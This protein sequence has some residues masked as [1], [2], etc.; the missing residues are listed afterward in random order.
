VVFEGPD[1]NWA[2]LSTAAYTA[3]TS[4]DN[5]INPRGL[6]CGLSRA[7]V[8]SVGYAADCLGAGVPVARLARNPA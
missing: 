7:T 8:R 3:D 5:F 4:A 1:S 6:D 2:A